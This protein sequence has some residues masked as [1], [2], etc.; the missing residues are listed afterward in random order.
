MK[1]MV[2]GIL[3]SLTLMGSS[4]YAEG[5]NSSAFVGKWVSPNDGTPIYSQMNINFCDDTHMHVNFEQIEN[6]EKLYD[7]TEYPGQI[8][9]MPTGELRSHIEFDYT[10]NSGI[11]KPGYMDI[12]M[13]SD[14]IWLSAYSYDNVKF[15]NNIMYYDGGTF[16]PYA[17]AYSYAVSVELNGG[18]Q[19]FENKPF[20]LKTL[21][22]IPLRGMLDSMNL[23]VYWDDYI[24]DGIHT[25]LI[26]TSRNNKI[27]QF[28]R[29]DSGRGF[30][31]WMLCRWDNDNPDTS[32]KN[33]EMIDICTSQPVMVDSKTYLPLRVLSESYGATVGWRDNTKTAFVS[34]NIATDTK[35]TGDDLAKIQNFSKADADRFAQYYS[36]MVCVDN[37]PYYTYK[38][39]YFIYWQDNKLYKINYNG[40]VEEM[41]VR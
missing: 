15:I 40:T 20:I 14:N 23:N 10:D 25:Q 30:S 32:S 13:F 9:R 38:S 27:L 35:K 18:M 2:I 37:T 6:G 31:P 41:P 29:N 19:S 34:D 5:F 17:S 39:K 33:G 12:A 36:G 26:T 21:T 4:A 8:V 24:N 22:Y 28:S 1:R 7:F 16:N 3:A 11:T